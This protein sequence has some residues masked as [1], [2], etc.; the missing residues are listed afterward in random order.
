MYTLF[1]KN[2][3]QGSG[4]EVESSMWPWNSL[5]KR[6]AV[7]TWIVVMHIGVTN[8]IS[9]TRTILFF[10]WLL[11]EQ[12]AT[13]AW[14]F[15]FYSFPCITCML[16]A[17]DTCLSFMM[18]IRYAHVFFYINIVRYSVTLASLC[19]NTKTFS[20]AE[21]WLDLRKLLRLWLVQTLQSWPKTVEVK[22]VLFQ[23]LKR[24]PWV[25][26]QG[27]VFRVELSSSRENV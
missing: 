17:S 7:W 18:H 20:L 21:H 23:R 2:I 10:L 22:D 13:N 19:L 25:L 6:Q 4:V 8:F 11:L 15:Y 16:H 12:H 26:F 5:L 27:I 1:V 3:H 14:Y 9:L 24:V